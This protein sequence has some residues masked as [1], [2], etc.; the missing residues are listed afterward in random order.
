M[1]EQYAQAIRC[2]GVDT[3]G[4]DLKSLEILKAV[5]SSGNDDMFDVPWLGGFGCLYRCCWRE[6]GKRV[7]L[8]TRK[9][10]IDTIL[11]VIFG[12]VGT[13]VPRVLEEG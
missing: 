3:L 2:Q 8:W 4:Q 6:G 5:A 9:C 11:R 12:A 10:Q 13:G 1:V 7:S